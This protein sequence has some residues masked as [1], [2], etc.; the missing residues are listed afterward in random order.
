[1]QLRHRLPVALVGA[2]W[3]ACGAPQVESHPP[4]AVTVVIDYGVAGRAR[5]TEQTL[6][7]AGA[8]P[9]EALLDVADVDQR[10]VS[11]TAADVWSVEGVATDVDAGCYWHWRLNGQHPR[12]APDRYRLKNGDHVTW[13]YV[14]GERPAYN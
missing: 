9:I 14:H 7:P 3:A 10:Y 13:T 11:R 6:L 2:V 8:S 12:E 4:V 5:E 1:M